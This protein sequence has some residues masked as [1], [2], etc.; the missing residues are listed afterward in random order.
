MEYLPEV[1]REFKKQYPKIYGTYNKLALSCNEVGPLDEKTREMVKLGIAI[2]LSSEGAIRSHTRRALAAGV[3]ADGVRQAALL[4]L[5]TAGFPTY[6]AAL[7][8]V[9]EVLAK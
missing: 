1:Y 6:I 5:T 4:A 9:N 7:K 2:G 8:W 3:S